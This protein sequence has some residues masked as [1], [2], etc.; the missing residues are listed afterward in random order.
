MS[1]NEQIQQIQ[2]IVD[3]Q[4]V[5][6]L[7]VLMMNVHVG[8]QIRN[9]AMVANSFMKATVLLKNNPG[10]P[11]RFKK[12]QEAVMNHLKDQGPPKP[13]MM[14]TPADVVFAPPSLSL[15]SS[16]S[17]IEPPLDLPNND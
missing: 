10:F 6:G 13:G 15:A 1:E 9:K 14:P 7:A 11:E 3:E 17:D 8:S 5:F 4:T 16:V 2:Q 12:A